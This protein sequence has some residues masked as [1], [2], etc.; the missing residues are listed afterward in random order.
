MDCLLFPTICSESNG[1]VNGLIFR[2]CPHD[3]KIRTNTA[4]MSFLP[5]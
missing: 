3:K 1:D 5:A 2:S 4:A